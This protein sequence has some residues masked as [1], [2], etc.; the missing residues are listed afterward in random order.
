MAPDLRPQP[1]AW[2][3][4]LQDCHPVGLTNGLLAFRPA[5]RMTWMPA[6]KTTRKPSGRES[7]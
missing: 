7:G 4:G 5:C 6:Y 3:S 1:P 2:P